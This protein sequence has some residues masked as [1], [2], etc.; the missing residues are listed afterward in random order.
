MSV[1][2]MPQSA[3]MKTLGYLP[4]Q[5]RAQPLLSK[6]FRACPYQEPC[7]HPSHGFRKPEKREIQCAAYPFRRSIE[8]SWH[9]PSV[10][11]SIVNRFSVREQDNPKKTVFHFCHLHPPAYSTILL[12]VLSDRDEDGLF[13]PL[14]LDHSPI[15]SYSDELEV[16]CGFHPP[17]VSELGS[18]STNASVNNIRCCM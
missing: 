17:N 15:W 16:V 14:V 3:H 1:S 9:K 13:N 4:E 6:C 7:F 18:V 11:K 10:K 5:M 12:N 8:F 2:L